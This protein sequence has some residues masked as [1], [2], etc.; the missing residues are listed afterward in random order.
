LNFYLDDFK[1]NAV[2]ARKFLKIGE[3]PANPKLDVSQ[4][5]AYALIA[6]TLLNLDETI[7]LN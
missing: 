4:L 6:N 7:T 5:V 2:E 3:K 1:Q